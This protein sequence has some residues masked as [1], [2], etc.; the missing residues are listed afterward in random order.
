MLALALPA[1]WQQFSSA[2]RREVRRVIGELVAAR[3]LMPQLMKVRNGDTWTPEERLA[4]R[5]G[6]RRLA[7][8]SPYLLVL[9]MPGSLLILPAYA[10]WLDR[11]RISRQD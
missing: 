11:R 8:V 9:L 6:L 4:L 10:W 3:G 5:D 7:K 2:Q 1:W